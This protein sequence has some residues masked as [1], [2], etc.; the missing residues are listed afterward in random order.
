[1]R[2]ADAVVDPM[3]ARTGLA[4]CRHLLPEARACC[5]RRSLEETALLSL[6]PRCEWAWPSW[7]HVLE[8][9]EPEVRSC[10]T[11]VVVGA[12]CLPAGEPPCGSARLR[13]VRSS[14]CFS[15]LAGDT[16]V[17]AWVSRGCYLVT[18]GWLRQWREAIAAWGYD[19]ETARAHFGEFAQAVL[20]L[21][22]GLDDRAPSRLHDFAQFLALRAELEPVGLD[23]F[24]DRLARAVECRP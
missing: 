3:C 8:S 24:G 18:P 11:V 10:D 23:A 19:I 5:H 1:V 22:T 20:L 12:G 6:E 21:D 9:L 2:P 16:T 14:T 7:A 13:V 4:V 17:D 15:L